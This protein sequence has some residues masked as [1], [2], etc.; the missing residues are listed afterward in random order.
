MDPHSKDG[1]FLWRLIQIPLIC[2]SRLRTIFLSG[3]T[4]ASSLSIICWMELIGD[5]STDSMVEFCLNIYLPE[6]SYKS[7]SMTWVDFSSIGIIVW[8]FDMK[9]AH[10]AAAAFGVLEVISPIGMITWVGLWSWS[11]KLISYNE[12]VSPVWYKVG[13][14]SAKNLMTQPAEALPVKLEKFYIKLLLDLLL[15]IIWSAV[16]GVFYVFLRLSLSYFFF[17]G[18]LTFNYWNPCTSVTL[19]FDSISTEKPV[20]IT[21]SL[22]GLIM[23]VL[24]KCLTT[25]SGQIILQFGSS[26]ASTSEI[27]LTMLAWLTWVNKITFASDGTMSF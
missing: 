27:A 26:E 23:F 4:W 1:S 2:S 24:R 15:S 18:L 19:I 8:Q 9:V 5:I 16:P 12:F 20:L 21:T 7:S 6:G 17:L 14:S 11:T 22:L 3:L 13:P 25:S 10:A